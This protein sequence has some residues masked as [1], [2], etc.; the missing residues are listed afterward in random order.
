MG[1]IIP[2]RR[3]RRWTRPEDYGHRPERRGGRGGGPPDDRKRPGLFRGLRPWVLLVALITLWVLLDPAI[4]EPPSFLST[5]PERV[6]GS[7][8]RCGA[9]KRDHCVIDGDTF[10]LGE[11]T[12]R[13][14]GIDAPEIHPARCPAEARAGE[15]A[16]AE[17]QRL[18]NQGAFMMTARFDK[19]S[20]RYGRELRVA[21]RKRADGSTRSIAADMLAGGT[22]RPYFGGLRRSWC[23]AK[24]GPDAP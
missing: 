8:G 14:I 15:A 9:A 18:L 10:K 7:F 20:D 12:I 17:L 23:P 4:Y 1:D 22:V 11:R 13:L 5:R 21:S 3:K 6:A 2:F 19:P 16:T 24:G